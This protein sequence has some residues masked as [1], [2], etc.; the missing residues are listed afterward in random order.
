M[1][2]TDKTRSRSFANGKK[3]SSSRCRYPSLLSLSRSLALL[4]LNGLP[5]RG[6]GVAPSLQQRR[7][8]GGRGGG[9]GGG[10]ELP[11]LEGFP[12]PHFLFYLLA[13]EPFFFFLL[14]LLSHILFLQPE[15]IAHTKFKTHQEKEEEE[16][17]GS[18]R[19]RKSFFLRLPREG[20][21]KG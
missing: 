1:T 11:T 6:V 13:I 18:R 14:L 19:R 21:R 10:K 17:E 12:S 3:R 5:G 15:D 2:R 20:G 4:I 16:E 9:G 8:Q 7:L